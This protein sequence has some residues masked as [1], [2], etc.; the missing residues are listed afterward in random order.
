M[1]KLAVKL[2]LVDTEEEIPELF[3]L[4]DSQVGGLIDAIQTVIDS[5]MLEEA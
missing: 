4:K 5:I 1:E 3:E 2:L